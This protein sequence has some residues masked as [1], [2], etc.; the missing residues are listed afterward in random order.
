MSIE[1]FLTQDVFPVC[2]DRSLSLDEMVAAGHF[3]RI[4]YQIL[5][6]HFPIVHSSTR[7]LDLRIALIAQGKSANTDEILEWMRKKRLAP[8]RIEELLAMAAILQEGYLLRS[9]HA[10]GSVWRNGDDIPFV[11]TCSLG[12]KRRLRCSEL[13]SIPWIASFDCFPCVRR[14][15]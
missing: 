10:L 5:S 9:A 8:A 4:D 13:N 6:G 11:P 14:G 2:I 1:L 3:G 12:K 7:M 15:R